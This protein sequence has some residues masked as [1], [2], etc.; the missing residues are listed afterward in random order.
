MQALTRRLSA[1][2]IILLTTA[3]LAQAQVRVEDTTPCSKVLPER[4]KVPDDFSLV[5]RSG[6]V[7]AFRGI[8]TITKLNASGQASIETIRRS[9]AKKEQAVKERQVSQQ[10]VRRVYVTVLACQFFDL[11]KS[12]WNNRVMDGS[13]SSMD[14]TAGGKM[15][16]VIVHHYAVTR[17]SSIVGALNT[18]LEK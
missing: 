4:V 13:V 14:V 18:A 1:G 12:Y 2:I 7:Q 9:G 16:R 5:F 10:A 3:A 15:H 17:F 8:S 6:P 11:D